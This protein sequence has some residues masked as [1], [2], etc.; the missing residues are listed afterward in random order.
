MGVLARLLTFTSDRTIKGKLSALIAVLMAAI[1]VFIYLFFPARLE[2]QARTHL[3][4]KAT[5]ICEMTAYSV[6]SALMFNDVDAAHNVFLGARQNPELE[7]MEIRDL[8]GEVFARFGAPAAAVADEVTDDGRYTAIV[9]VRHGDREIGVVQAGFSLTKLD[10]SVARSR[11]A[12]AVVS[13]VVFALAVVAVFGITAIVTSPLNRMVEVVRTIDRGDMSQRA[14]VVAR[15][16]V[17]QLAM[18]FNDMV[19]S[20]EG[21][22]RAL[23]KEIT[24][25]TRAEEALRQSEEANRALLDAVPDLMFR[26][27]RNGVYLDVKASGGDLLLPA[28]QVVGQNLS[29]TL[30]PRVARQAMASL[31]RALTTGAL[32][33]LE[34]DLDIDGQK[35]YFEA[36]LSPVVGDEVF[37][38]VR[39]ISE[40]RA[41][42][43]AI[44][45]AE[46][47][48]EAQRTLSMRSDRLRSLGEMAAGIA[49]ELNQPLMG[50][51]G[52]AEHCLIAL[53]RRWILTEDKLRQRLSAIVEQ[54]DRMS[55]IIEHV[56]M[57]AREAGG[58]AA[59]PVDVN[60]VVHSALGMISAQFGSH[61]LQLECELGDDLP[62]VEA[63]QFSLE[64]VLLNLINNAR[65]A[66]E[67]DGSR[68]GSVGPR[69]LV[70]TT[71]AGEQGD[72][73]RVRIDVADNGAG[74]RPEILEKVFDPF[75]TTKDPDK[76]TG[77]GLS[78]S[79]S[80]VEEYH[81]E[82]S[83]ESSPGQGTTTTI[84]LPAN[85]RS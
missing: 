45:E 5:S 40:Q 4:D 61:G 73:Q 33:T 62:S 13:L 39:D 23:E 21:H 83:I 52:L 64:E 84:L 12:V 53:S 37:A 44:R 76:G 49:H 60:E 18:A 30:P 16:E 35:R 63:N 24:E 6:S 51:R 19:G 29:D 80:I 20:I 72:G 58:D 38:I 81:G 42:E 1:S 82:L 57:F 71:V 79:K 48:L 28:A 77:L 9:P 47:T 54:S 7:Y 15:D 56:R 11:N 65:D 78:I 55:H 17:G 36:R 67:D 8:S 85:A 59:Q 31:R 27:D 41:A 2:E 69:V 75:F 70:R 25:R 26:F 22:T 3:Q 14:P 74:I 50:V 32:E 66:V 68:T 46:Q 10:E 43:R 34:Y